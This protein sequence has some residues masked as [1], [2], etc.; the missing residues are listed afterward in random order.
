VATRALLSSPPLAL[1]AFAFASAALLG[2]EFLVAFLRDGAV[3]PW[4]A[5]LPFWI[6]VAGVFGAFWLTAAASLAGLRSWSPRRLASLGAFATAGLGAILA[7][8]EVGDPRADALALGVSATCFATFFLLRTS[9]PRAGSPPQATR[10]A[11]RSR[12]Q[13]T[14]SGGS[15]SKR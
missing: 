3:Q 11:P 12:A 5:P 15:V 10:D 8:V 4:V 13:N 1:A 2:E 6:G 7:R 9:A 14:Q